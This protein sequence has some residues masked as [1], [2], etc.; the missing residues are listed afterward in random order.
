[1]LASANVF[2]DGLDMFPISS[3]LLALDRGRYRDRNRDRDCDRDRGRDTDILA[4]AAARH[5]VANE[6]LILTLPWTRRRRR[7][8]AAVTPSNF[9]A[10]RAGDGGADHVLTLLVVT[11]QAVGIHFATVGDGNRGGRHET[12]DSDEKKGGNLHGGL[13]DSGRGVALFVCEDL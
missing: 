9:T 4:D 2:V 8:H 5:R 11:A 10:R 7:I 6:N 13:V 1:M 12:K 3:L